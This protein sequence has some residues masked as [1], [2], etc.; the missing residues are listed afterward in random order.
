MESHFHWPWAASLIYRQR[1]TNIKAAQLSSFQERH[2]LIQLF[3]LK[4]WFGPRSNTEVFSVV[5]T[6]KVTNFPT[7]NCKQVPQELSKMTVLRSSDNPSQIQQ[8]KLIVQYC[9]MQLPLQKVLCVPPSSGKGLH[10]CAMLMNS[11][12]PSWHLYVYMARCSQATKLFRDST[13]KNAQMHRLLPEVQIQ[14]SVVVSQ[15]QSEPNVM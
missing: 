3:I 1:S 5:L 11:A 8:H 6:A 10:L 9:R 13:G 14:Y 7:A 12:H 4:S 15:I 2:F